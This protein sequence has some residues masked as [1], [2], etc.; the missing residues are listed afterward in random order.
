LFSPQISKPIRS[1]GN[2]DFYQFIMI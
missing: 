1:L 2:N